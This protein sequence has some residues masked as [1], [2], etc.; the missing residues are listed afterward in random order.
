[1]NW[2][3]AAVLIVG[4]SAVFMAAGLAARRVGEWLAGPYDLHDVW[5]DYEDPKDFT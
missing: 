3:G 4:G 1:M 2:L 5:E